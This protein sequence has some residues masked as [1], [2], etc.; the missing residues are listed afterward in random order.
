MRGE[1]LIEG[2]MASKQLKGRK[3]NRIIDTT[4]KERPH[5]QMKRDGFNRTEWMHYCN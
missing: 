5:G 2:R 3:I 4:R 1:C